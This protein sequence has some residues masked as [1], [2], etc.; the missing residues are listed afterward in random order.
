MYEDAMEL[1][2]SGSRPN[3]NEALCCIWL[4][5][6]S[7][8]DNRDRNMSGESVFTRATLGLADAMGDFPSIQQKIKGAHSRSMFLFSAHRAVSLAASPSASPRCIMRAAMAFN[9]FMHLDVCHRADIFLTHEQATRAC[10]YGWTFLRLW[11]QLGLEDAQN[12]LCGYKVRPKLHAFAHSLLELM[13]TKDR[14]A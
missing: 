6:I 2:Q 3:V 13:D 8:W 1:V 9:L 12:N 7:F 5:Y 4:L 10:A 14:A 11:Q